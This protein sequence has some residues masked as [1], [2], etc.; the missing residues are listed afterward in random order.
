V[1]SVEE[2]PVTW[3]ELNKLLRRTN[4]ESV[5][6][7]MIASERAGF[8]RVRWIHRMYE[9]YSRLR[10]KRERKEVVRQ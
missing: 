6:L 2:S 7:E 8:G 3:R 5:V 10:R 4:K 1:N 9:R